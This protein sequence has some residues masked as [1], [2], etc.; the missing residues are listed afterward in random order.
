MK[1]SFQIKTQNFIK[2]GKDVC[3]SFLILERKLNI[4]DLIDFEVRT[5]PTILSSNSMV[6]KPNKLALTNSLPLKNN[7]NS[8][9]I[10]PNLCKTDKGG[11]LH[12]LKW[13]LRVTRNYNSNNSSLSDGENSYALKS[14]V[15]NRSHFNE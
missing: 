3:K 5:I 1:R 8:E 13:K 6:R 15:F 2:T 9:Q 10:N 4:K 7:S 14:Y 12:V 11:F